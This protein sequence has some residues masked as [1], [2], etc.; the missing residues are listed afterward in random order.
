MRVS[1]KKVIQNTN[2]ILLMLQHQFGSRIESYES[3]K[4]SRFWIW[5]ISDKAFFLF[6]T[7][8]LPIKSTF[9]LIMGISN[10]N[11]FSISPGSK[12]HHL[13]WSH[14]SR[15]IWQQV[16]ASRSP[17]FFHIQSVNYLRRQ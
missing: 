13:R 5:R 11:P 12:L 10:I 3:R 1:N 2:Y 7:R 4:Y 9:T 15:K 16:K 8:C 17:L 14:S 6:G